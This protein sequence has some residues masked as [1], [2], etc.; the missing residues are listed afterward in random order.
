MNNII[1]N[2]DNVHKLSIIWLVPP[3]IPIVIL[4]FTWIATV[5]YRESCYHISDVLVAVVWSSSPPSFIISGLSS[6]FQLGMVWYGMVWYGRVCWVAIGCGSFCIFFFRNL[7]ST[8][9]PCEKLCSRFSFAHIFSPVSTDHYV[10]NFHSWMEVH[11]KPYCVVAS[12]VNFR[13]YCTL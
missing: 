1:V 10:G 12:E 3:V 13:V 4:V 7:T 5:G 11:N 2:F 8:R 9:C 6:N